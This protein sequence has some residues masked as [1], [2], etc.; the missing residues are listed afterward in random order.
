MQCSGRIQTGWDQCGNSP[1]SRPAIGPTALHQ[2][3]LFIFITAIMH[4]VL[5]VLLILASSLRLHFWRRWKDSD[6]QHAHMYVDCMH[7]MP[8]KPYLAHLIPQGQVHT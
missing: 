7:V 1:N 5:G 4:I 6:D 2:I 3:H 8:F